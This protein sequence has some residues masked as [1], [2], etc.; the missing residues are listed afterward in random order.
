MR[1]CAGVFL[2]RRSICHT[3]YRN[4]KSVQSHVAIKFVDRNI[5]HAAYGH[6]SVQLSHFV[7]YWRNKNQNWLNFSGKYIQGLGQRCQVTGWT[8]RSTAGTYSSTFIVR[9]SRFTE[10]ILAFNGT[11]LRFQSRHQQKVT[12]SSYRNFS[13]FVLHAQC[14]FYVSWTLIS[15]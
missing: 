13:N 7:T 2:R 8:I 4:Y 11:L 15:R 9:K 6:D 5:H 10:I 12:E 1:R 14:A 3:L